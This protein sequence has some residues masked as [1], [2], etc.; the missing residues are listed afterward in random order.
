MSHDVTLDETLFPRRTQNSNPPIQLEQLNQAQRPDDFFPEEFNPEAPRLDAPAPARNDDPQR[1]QVEDTDSE[2]NDDD[3]YTNRPYSSQPKSE[4]EPDFDWDEWYCR[5]LDEAFE[6]YESGSEDYRSP[7]CRS[8]PQGSDQAPP[9]APLSPGSHPRGPTRNIPRDLDERWQQESEQ[10]FDPY[11]PIPSRPQHLGA[12]QCHVSDNAYGDVPP[13]EAWR[14]Q[15]RDTRQDQQEGW[16]GVPAPEQPPSSLIE[17][18]PPEFRVARS[19][20]N[21]L[22][23]ATNGF[24]Q[25]YKEAM[26]RDDVKQWKQAMCEELKSQHE[27]KTWR[28]VPRPKNRCIVKCKWVYVI[29]PNS[30]YKASLVAK[31]FT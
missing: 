11:L 20:W 14:Q 24:P 9:H 15:K 30:L 6:Q 5:L 19:F 27:N 10:R 26:K 25:A 23:H 31:G 17:V 3:L 4:S 21:I 7:S 28:L 29:K 22:A 2:S 12:G 8:T 18:D 13:T 16:Q 1:A